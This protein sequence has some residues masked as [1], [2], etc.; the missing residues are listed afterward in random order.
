[1][2][3]QQ[4]LAGSEGPGPKDCLEFTTGTT[5]R[6]FNL[7]LRQRALQ[8][9]RTIT[10]TSDVSLCRSSSVSHCCM[11]ALVDELFLFVTLACVLFCEQVGSDAWSTV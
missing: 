4:E 10:K 1:M 2:E 7:R 6:V 3:L 11:N 9:G 5:N 8:D